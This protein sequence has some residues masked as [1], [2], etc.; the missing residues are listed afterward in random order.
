MHRPR[1][2][3]PGAESVSTW[4]PTVELRTM[5]YMSEMR[6]GHDRP[7]VPVFVHARPAV[8]Y[9]NRPAVELDQH[10]EGLAGRG[11]H[12]EVHRLRVHPEQDRRRPC[13]RI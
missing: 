2:Q 1:D 11:R 3:A 9:G 7:A 10:V 8:G 4:S 5:R 6:T 13:G 12:H